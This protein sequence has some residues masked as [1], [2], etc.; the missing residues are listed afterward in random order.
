MIQL[1]KIHIRFCHSF[2]FPF[3]FPVG[4]LS[5]IMAKALL[6][7]T[8]TTV[9]RLG[10][11]VSSSDTITWGGD[12]SRASYQSN[13]NMD[14]A[15]VGSSDFA[16]IFKVKTPGAYNGANEQFFGQVRFSMNKSG[17]G[18]TIMAAPSLYDLGWCPVCLRC[19]DPEQC[20]QT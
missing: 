4:D 12:N 15:V 6:W 9:V 3:V 20:V 19:D 1:L 13:H 17:M 8:L 18:L 10:A 2:G 7:V 11:C 16:Q 5:F 14:P